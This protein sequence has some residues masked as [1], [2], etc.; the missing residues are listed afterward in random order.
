MTNLSV[1]QHVG[2]PS[3]RGTEQNLPE[4]ARRPGREEHEDHHQGHVEGRHQEGHDLVLLVLLLAEGLVCRAGC[5]TGD[6]DGIGALYLFLDPLEVGRGHLK[7]F[8]GAGS[9][10][11]EGQRRLGGLPSGPVTRG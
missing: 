3:G 10:R 11:H 5:P 2:L 4:D 1:D 6:G 7:L 8:R 9:P